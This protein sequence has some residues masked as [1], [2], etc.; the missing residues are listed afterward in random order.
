[1]VLFHQE[2]I[3]TLSPGN[4]AP[5]WGWATFLLP[6]MEGNSVFLAIDPNRPI[7]DPVHRE[8]ISSQFPALLCPSSSGPTEPFEVVNGQ[9][10]PF[11]PDAQVPLIL[12]RTHY[13]ASHGQESAW[14]SEAGA[15]LRGSVFSNIYTGT[16]REVEIFGQVSRVADGP[17]YRNSKTRFG[18]IRDGLAQTIFFGEHSSRLSDKTWVGV[19]PSAVVH[20]RI[21]TPLN[22]PMGRQRWY[23]F[24]RDPRVVNWTFQARPLSIQLTFQPCTLGRCMPSIHR[25]GTLPW[26]MPRC[27]SSPGRLTRLSS[28][29]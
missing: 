1:M 20:P 7:W 23:W 10:Q 29:S 5:G 6:F 19:V 12:G 22:G 4:A 16:T 9:M 15:D 28:Q 3:L 27:T 8:L 25:V 21:S 11:S 18:Q 24:M 26:A 2:P 17:F 13:V 14:G